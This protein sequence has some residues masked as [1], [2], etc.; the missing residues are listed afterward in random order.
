MRNNS[1]SCGVC[2]E[3]QMGLAQSVE[4]LE[5]G[6]RVHGDR[7]FVYFVR[8]TIGTQQIL[9]ERRNTGSGVFGCGE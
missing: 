2:L 3:T 6:E 8:S 5:K 1:N 7:M 9:V 4:D